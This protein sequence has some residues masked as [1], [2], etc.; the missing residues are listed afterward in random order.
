MN[1]DAGDGFHVWRQPFPEGPE[2]I[3]SG[4]AEEEG[5]AVA[6]DGRS[7][8]TSVGIRERALSVHG[9]ASERQISVEGVAY[10]PRFSADGQ[11]ICYRIAKTQDSGHGK[12]ALFNDLD[13]VTSTAE[14]HERGG[15]V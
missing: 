2:Q 9:T 13:R 15:L 6:P 11:K 12:S 1:V 7:V 5:L 10:W 3:T 4:P 14:D 8:I